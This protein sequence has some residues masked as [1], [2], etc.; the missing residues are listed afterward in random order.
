MANKFELYI[1][2]LEPRHS[3]ST[4][5]VS[6]LAQ[7]ST[8]YSKSILSSNAGECCARALDAR[9]PRPF[10]FFFRE[11]S[12][13]LSFGDPF[14][15]LSHVSEG[16]WRTIAGAGG[17]RPERARAGDARVHAQTRSLALRRGPR[18]R[19]A[20]ERPACFTPY[21]AQFESDLDDREFKRFAR[22][23]AFQNTLDRPRPTPSQPRSKI[24]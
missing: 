8:E 22:S 11:I 23:V 12:L 7:N 5:S 2:K 10:F 16:F 18:G 3:V 19:R 21:L 15:R 4:H 17:G 6:T 14:W 20:R 13:L 1:L 9:R 24:K